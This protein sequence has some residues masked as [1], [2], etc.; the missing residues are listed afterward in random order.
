MVKKLLW[1]A[2]YGCAYGCAFVSSFSWAYTGYLAGHPPSVVV[3]VVGAFVSF[4]SVW[5]V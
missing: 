1:S 5:R 3:G 4:V 2:G